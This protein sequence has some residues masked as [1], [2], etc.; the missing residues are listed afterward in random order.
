M[1]FRIRYLFCFVSALLISPVAWGLVASDF[2]QTDLAQL[3]GADRFY[4]NGIEGQGA[5][6][7]VIEGGLAW[8]GDASTAHIAEYH[9]HSDTWRL[10][11]GFND[12]RDLWD[13]HATFVAGILGGRG[14]TAIR[15]GIAPGVDLVSGAIARRWVGSS[16]TLN[17][18][19]SQATILAPYRHFTENAPVDVINSS[20]GYS[21]APG[22]S[23]ITR[24]IDAIAASSPG[25][26]FVA[27]A[28]NSG[29][30]SNSVV[31]PASGVNVLAVGGLGYDGGNYGE[32]DPASSRGY[33]DYW[34]PV[35]G[36]VSGVRSTVELLAPGR[37]L[38]TVRYGGQ[39][40]GNN[41]T[42]TGSFAEA[43]RDA[44]GLFGTS[45][46][47]PMVSGG[48]AL[49]YSASYDQM[50]ANAASRDARVIRAVLMNSAAKLPGWDAS[51]T[52]VDSVITT[53][54]GLDPNQGA[55]RMDL[56]AA[57]DQYLPSAGA[58]AGVMTGPVNVVA[59]RGWDLAQVSLFDSIFYDLGFIGPGA[60]QLTSTLVWHRDMEIDA[61]SNVSEQKQANLDLHL[62]KLANDSPDWT[63]LAQSISEY[64]TL[65]HLYIPLDGGN[66]YRLEVRYT[67]NIFALS[68]ASDFESFAL[69]WNMEFIPEPVAAWWFGLGVMVLVVTVRRR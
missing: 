46:A 30:S 11:S 63:L 6:V 42:L 61:F 10:S 31:G 48:A 7:A 9:S 58:V 65:E 17:F 68:T 16:F 51:S 21:D 27:A 59:K 4:A 13:R 1:L 56:A 69:A 15:T 40:G 3:L 50:P 55:G 12:E 43:T 41:P 5:R 47:A 60:W 52:E 64:N 53:R 2:L 67:N 45:F 24:R 18:T 54:H 39:T 49:L 26:L 57:W 34:D 28:G 25:T 36:V 20:W 29:A 62:W 23:T 66:D 8:N 37:M 44:A 38:T 32:R 35:N 33:S 14:P 19:V 22:N